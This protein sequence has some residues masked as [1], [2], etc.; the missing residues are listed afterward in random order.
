MVNQLWAPW[1]MEYILAS[2]QAGCFLCDAAQAEVDKDHLVLQRR[3][4]TFTLLNRYP[5]TN[6]HCMTVPY[7]HISELSDLTD[8]EQLELMQATRDCVTILRQT[9]GIHGANVGINLGEAAGAGLA[10]HLHIHIVPRWQGDTNFMPVMADTRVMPQSL[11][12]T[13]DQLL[14]AFQIDGPQP[15]EPP[16]A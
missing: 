10:E 14:P 4:H 11:L 8:A 1:R 16:C 6:G 15:L 9:M 2:K 5:Y 3:Q 7:R 12:D 13:Y